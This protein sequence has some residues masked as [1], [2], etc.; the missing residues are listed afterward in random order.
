[1]P[2]GKKY[3]AAAALVEVNKNY[4]LVEAVA[5]LKKTSTTKFDSSVELHAKLGIDPAKGDQQVRGNISLPNGTGKEKRVAV[6]VEGEKAK[7]AKAAGADL[8]GGAELIEEIKKTGACNFDVAVATPDM[9]KVLSG[10]ARV[11]GPKGLMPNPKNETVTTQIGKIVAELKKGRLT[12]KNDDTANIHQLV[13][14]ISWDEA[15]L[16]DNIQALIDAIN[17]AK[18][19][20][21]KGVYLQKVYLTTTMGPSIRLAL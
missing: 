10:V 7:E 5:L 17:K 21:S 12:F 11:L 14:K 18:P 9:M 2:R 4:P 13:G 1:M 3:Q 19:S 16:V 15:K 20:S 6:F 8:V